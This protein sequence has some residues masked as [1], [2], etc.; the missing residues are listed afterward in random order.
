MFF[1]KSYI[2]KFFV[3]E[4]KNTEYLTPAITSTMFSNVN[5]FIKFTSNSTQSA[6]NTKSSKGQKKLVFQKNG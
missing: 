4:K 1:I 2:L 5:K 6:E 3:S